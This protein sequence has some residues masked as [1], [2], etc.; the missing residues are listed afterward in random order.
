MDKVKAQ[1]RF[2]DN[3]AGLMVL[4]NGKVVNY[5]VIRIEDGYL[6]YYTNEAL[7]VL[8]EGN[9]SIHDKNNREKIL[10]RSEEEL[11]E[12]GYVDKIPLEDINRVLF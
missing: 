2:K 3:H 8:A 4:K 5:G 11:M 10:D 9:L 6:V 12:A 1:Q 7:K